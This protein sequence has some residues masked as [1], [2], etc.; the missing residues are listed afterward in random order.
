MGK[1]FIVTF[2]AFFVMS[3]A[4]CFGNKMDVQ[5]KNKSLVIV[6][7]PGHGGSQS[8]AARDNEAIE[9]KS[10]N[11][12]IAEYLKAELESYEQV[13]VYLTRTEDKDVELADR[14]QFA[15]RKKAD[16]L[17]SL[18]NNAAG[19]CAA[20]DHGCTVLAAK[21][22]YKNNLALEGQKLSCN[23]LNE[24]S[25][26]GLTDQGILLRDSEANERYSNRVLADYY[27]IIRG[28][29]EN[30][31]LAVL[32]EHAFID[33]DS[34]YKNY[35]SSDKKLKRLAHAD[36]M[37]IVRYYQLVKK[38]QTNASNPGESSTEKTASK[39]WNPEKS[40]IEKC[41]L[42][43]LTNYKEKL[44]HAVDGNAKHNK[45]SYRIYYNEDNANVIDN[46]SATDNGQAKETFQNIDAIL[47]REG[48]LNVKGFSGI[49][50][51]K[52]LLTFSV[53]DG[54]AKV[55]KRNKNIESIKKKKLP[56][57]KEGY[58]N[59]MKLMIAICNIILLGC[60]FAGIMISRRNQIKVKDK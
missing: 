58:G 36:A 44:V 33:S 2:W 13:K 31:M 32:V 10:L 42:E 46:E 56:K 8:G 1:Y 12:K 21:L 45:I 59:K 15:V 9:E 17:I 20:Y 11:L 5:A 38:M 3:I 23:I 54:K 51:R 49:S 30:D 18:H 47:E 60:I 22:G 52:Q 50:L 41:D 39:K 53:L 48:L 4:V 40:N 28:G 16:A 25:G 43:P 55:E 57:K 37:G 7:D 35:L 24:L 14:I 34:D 26:M 19:E 6:L 27:A 29:V